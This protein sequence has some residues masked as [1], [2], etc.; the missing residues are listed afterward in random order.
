MPDIKL[1]VIP[2]PAKGTRAIIR[3]DKA[4]LLRGEGQFNYLCG[5]C[6]TVLLKGIQE[7]QV[8]GIVLRCAGCGSFNDTP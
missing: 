4:P 1:K 6:G 7:G 2:E 5:K 8:T 3:G